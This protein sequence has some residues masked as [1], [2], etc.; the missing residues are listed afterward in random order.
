MIRRKV[1]DKKLKRTNRHTIMFNNR[2]LDVLNAYC[3]K[4]KIRNRSKFMREAIIT[5]VLK[6]LD[7]DYPTLWNIGEHNLFSK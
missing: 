3:A 4:Y 2:E 5:T 7:D 6:K 1:K